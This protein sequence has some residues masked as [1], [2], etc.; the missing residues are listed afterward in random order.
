MNY[1]K[2]HSKFK[3]L[4][5]TTGALL[6]LAG[7]PIVQNNSLGEYMNTMTGTITAQAAE[8]TQSARWVGSG[9]RWQVSDNAGG[10]LKN[11][12]FQDDVTGHWYLLGAEDGSVMYAGLVTD[13]STGCTF[14]MNVSHDGTYGRM[15]STNG[16]YNINGKSISLTFN[17]NHDGT[18]GAITS[19][20]SE[21]RNTGVTE[22]S[23]SS[24]PTADNTTTQTNIDSDGNKTQTKGSYYDG[25]T[26]DSSDFDQKTC[27]YNKD[28]KLT[29]I[30]YEDY[31]SMRAM[32]GV[33]QGDLTAGGNIH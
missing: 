1:K 4:V 21:V 25:M 29:G 7:S 18:F 3:R 2:K 14:L 11:T 33:E 32:D 6:L 5:I 28:G 19:G 20:L 10:Y 27:D 16:V 30:E 9:D 22:K 12:W 26:V 15:I 13:Q 17:Q 8:L 24:I 23:L 31:K